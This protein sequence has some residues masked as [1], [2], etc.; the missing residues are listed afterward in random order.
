MNKS[1][2]YQV[3]TTEYHDAATQRD[4]GEKLPEADVQ[5]SKQ[6]EELEEKQEEDVETVELKYGEIK[7]SGSTQ[8]RQTACLS[9]SL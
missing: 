3:D 6:E 2:S 9:L 7:L 5:K 8:N 1:E 4:H